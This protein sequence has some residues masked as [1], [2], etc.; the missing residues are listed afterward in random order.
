[1]EFRPV[2]RVLT[3]EDNAQANGR[4]DRE[5]DRQTDGHEIN[6]RLSRVGESA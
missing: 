6:R 3:Y 1:M 2:K 4:R 5:I